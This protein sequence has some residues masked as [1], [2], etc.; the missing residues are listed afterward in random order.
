MLPKG[1][2]GQ[3]PTR[4]A[5]CKTLRASHQNAWFDCSPFHE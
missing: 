2:T 5:L 3:S 1:D 4:S